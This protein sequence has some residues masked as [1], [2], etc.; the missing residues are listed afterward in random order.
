MKTIRWTRTTRA[1][2]GL[3]LA[4][5]LMLTAACSE[6]SD[7]KENSLSDT[8]RASV[9][10]PDKAATGTP[11]KVGFV[12]AEGG[13]IDL[14]STRKAAEASAKYVNEHLGGLN[15]HPIE[16]ITCADKSDGASGVACANKL[17]EDGVV[18][19]T[20]G[21]VASPDLY[22][23][24]L[25][26]A[27]IPWI[28]MQPTG[29]KELTSDVAFAL[30]G[31]AVS[32]FG[33]DAAFAKE[34]G[35]DSAVLFSI[36]VPSI[37]GALDSLAVPAFEQ[38]GVELSSVLVPPGTPDV[39]PQVAAGMGKEPGVVFVIGDETLCQGF[40]PA[41][42]NTNKDQAPVVFSG[43]CA[44]EN[45]LEAVGNDVTEGMVSA[46]LTIARDGTPEGDLYY[47]ITEEYGEAEDASGQG[48]EG[49]ATVVGLARAVNA[50]ALDGD[51]TAA[52]VIEALH[53]AKD[54]QIPGFPEG[55]TFTCDRKASAAFSA[56]C[57]TYSLFG[58]VHDGKLG[59]YEA[60]QG[61]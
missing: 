58:T 32:T 29:Q 28:A 55:A 53:T 30:T 50:A 25:E 21:H 54:I 27:G 4:G 48:A 12:T 18:A 9:L 6:E 37:S 41:I 2:G 61:G 56:L 35:A 10:G 36:D 7:A 16:L 15:G 49:F 43:S 47:A 60:V 24:I 59:D 39:T 38:A 13:T 3:L 46:G 44:T 52:S 11:V 23:P 57:S 34:K 22:M 20:V 33:A 26:G 8:D 14:S 45:V 5:A 42:Q 17:V 1:A 19:V 40:L 51:V 31:G